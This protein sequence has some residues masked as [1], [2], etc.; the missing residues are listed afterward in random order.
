VLEYYRQAARP[1][2]TVDASYDPPPVVFEKISRAME[3]D[4]CSKDRR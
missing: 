4:D 2:I 1:V 3:Q